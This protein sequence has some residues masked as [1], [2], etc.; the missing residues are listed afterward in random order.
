MRNIYG[1]SF[2]LSFPL[3]KGNQ[4]ADCLFTRGQT[5]L[6]IDF[7]FKTFPI[8]KCPWSISNHLTL[9][10]GGNSREASKDTAD[11]PISSQMHKLLT[12]G[13]PALP[14]H[15]SHLRSFPKLACSWAP[16]QINSVNFWKVGVTHGH[17][18]KVRG[19]GQGEGRV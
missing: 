14:A 2:S 18:V 11:S 6:H 3:S 4:A 10:S 15:H 13:F 17:F 9:G 8:R 1:G 5:G 16:P 12:Q 19:R 7:Q